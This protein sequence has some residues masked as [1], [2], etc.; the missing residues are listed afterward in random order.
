[1]KAIMMDL[2]TVMQKLSIKKENKIFQ[3]VFT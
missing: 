3:K 2:S 1:M